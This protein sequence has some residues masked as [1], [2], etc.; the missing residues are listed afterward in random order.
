MNHNTTA[1]QDQVTAALMLNYFTVSVSQ[2]IDYKDVY[3]LEHEYNAIINNLNMEECL[4]DEALKRMFNR[5]L[6]VITRFRIQEGDRQ[7][8]QREYQNNMRNALFNCLPSMNVIVAGGNPWTLLISAAHQVGTAYFNYRRNKN[9]YQMQKDK[10]EWELTKG[11]WENCNQ[12]RKE[13]FNAQWDM[14]GTYKIPD[15]YLLKEKQLADYNEILLDEDPQRRLERLEYLEADFR[16]FPP[17]WFYCAQAAGDSARLMQENKKADQAQHY[18]ADK[19]KHL[20]QFDACWM[21]ILRSDVFAFTSALERVKELDHVVEKDRII[22][23]LDRVAKHGKYERDIMQVCALEYL[24]VGESA[25]AE[26]LLKW[27]VNGD[28][29]IPLNARILSSIYVE[30]GREAEYKIL[31]DR[32]PD[33][34]CPP[35]KRLGDSFA[36]VQNR[37]RDECRALIDQLAQKLG[38]IWANIEFHDFNVLVN[39]YAD[40]AFED[41]DEVLA[42]FTVKKF[43]KAHDAGLASAREFLASYPMLTDDDDIPAEWAMPVLDECEKVAAQAAKSMRVAVQKV[44]KLAQE[45]QSEKPSTLMRIVK[46]GL[47]GTIAG[48]FLGPIGIGAAIAGNLLH[49]SAN[50]G[51]FDKA[52]KKYNNSVS[53]MIEMTEKTQESVAVQVQAILRDAFWDDEFDQEAIDL[54]RAHVGNRIAEAETILKGDQEGRSDDKKPTE[55]DTASEPGED[56]EG[57]TD[58]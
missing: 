12:L 36:D 33:N 18:R 7:W 9:Q 51:P 19:I 39:I 2:I 3:I 55:V 57:N 43:A 38:Q 34:V 20:D 5:I 42:Y 49:D 15:E 40:P 6:D 4:K 31:A 27:M 26:R 14:S 10:G 13:L 17:F 29:N 24:G 48:T 32:E 23:L 54:V 8:L 30:S 44:N 25:K 58:N 1:K 56:D 52:L 45:C 21:P 50:D 37:Q 11:A 35:S 47:V 53:K 16:A 28:Y 46:G 22:S 41:I